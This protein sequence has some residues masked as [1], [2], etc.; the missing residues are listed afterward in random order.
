[1]PEISE[2]D[3]AALAAQVAALS[4][5]L[6]AA[7]N[8]I[9]DL[10][11][12]AGG[13]LGLDWGSSLVDSNSP[14]PNISVDTIE[15][16]GG[17]IRQDSHGMQILTS[18]ASP[19]G[20]VYWP[21]Y[22]PSSDPSTVYPRAELAG[23]SNGVAI[24]LLR[25]AAYRNSTNYADVSAFTGIA[26]NPQAW[27][28]TTTPSY[29]AGVYA[30]AYEAGG[31]AQVEWRGSLWQDKTDLTQITSDQNDY[32]VGAKQRSSIGLSSDAARN[33]TGILATSVNDG[34]FLFI[35][36]RGS[37]AITLKDESASSS[38]A[39]RFALNADLVLDADAG[40]ILQYD[41]TSSRWRA[42]GVLPTTSGGSSMPM[43]PIVGPFTSQPIA[44]YLAASGASA[45]ASSTWPSA[46][47]AIFFP[48]IV[49]EDCTI[50]KL[51]V[52]NGATVSGNID[53]GVYDSSG[54]RKISSG[55][56]T[57]TGTSILQEFNVADT[58]ITAGLYYVAVA[59]DN[60]T[61]TVIRH[62]VP[63]LGGAGVETAQSL[64]IAIQ[65]TAFA[66]PST[67]TLAADSRAFI[68]WAGFSVSPRTLV[69]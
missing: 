60:T 65:A 68:P 2:Q 38:A 4:S 69:T 25:L 27:L 11:D 16:G 55:S 5:Q 66:L 50:T 43:P 6:T 48:V 47:E 45:P 51:W 3:F 34:A 18:G 17:I 36:N 54:T 31:S 62:S 26:T 40:C 29:N 41:A 23:I 53:V 56:Q 37:F 52:Y 20:T 13:H 9:D 24:A 15:S 32:D 8:R 1:M 61:G 64:G 33:I 19:Y 58:A 21:G 12:F 57:Q 28:N 46:N 7:R 30:L 49:T 42:L 10:E 39:N 44:G 59:M 14:H 22:A 35:Q 67:A 63:A